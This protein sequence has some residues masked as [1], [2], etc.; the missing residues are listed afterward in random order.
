MKPE[1]L[2][3]LGATVHVKPAGWRR[4]IRLWLPLFLVWLLVLPLLILLLP[5]LLVGALVMG[6]NLWRSLKAINGVLAA[7]RGTHV[8]VDNRDTKFFIRLH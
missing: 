6:I 5:F 4:G 7:T 3:P 1:I 2:P 8:E